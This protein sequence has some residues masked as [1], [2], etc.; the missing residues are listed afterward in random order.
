[1][2]Q[3][4]GA[5][6]ETEFEEDAHKFGVKVVEGTGYGYWQHAAEVTFD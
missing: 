1:M 6:S 5:G 3:M 4:V 2:T